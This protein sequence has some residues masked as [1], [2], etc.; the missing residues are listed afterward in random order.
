ENE[1][2]D[3]P[4]HRRSHRTVAMKSLRQLSALDPSLD[5]LEAVLLQPTGERETHVLAADARH[6]SIEKHQCEVLRLLAAERVQMPEVGTDALERWKGGT[7]RSVLVAAGIAQQPKPFFR[8]R[9][10]DVVLAREITID[11]GRAVFD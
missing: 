7:L 10:E 9:K 2:T 4:D 8:E 3:Y 11:C 1:A 6:G 5:F